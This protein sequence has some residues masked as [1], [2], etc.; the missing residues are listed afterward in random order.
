MHTTAVIAASTTNAADTAVTIDVT[1]DITVADAAAAN[2]VTIADNIT[3]LIL[4]CIVVICSGNISICGG[5]GGYSNGALKLFE[6]R[7]RSRRVVGTRN[8]KQSTFAD[9]ATVNVIATTT[10]DATVATAANIAASTAAAVATDS[11]RQHWKQARARRQYFQ[12][13]A[14][15]RF[16]NQLESVEIRTLLLFLCVQVR[17]KL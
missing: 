2:A 8:Y 1:A 9:A 17:M 4:V 13:N 11:I 14:A 5:G 12:Q 3:L 7:G 6:N 10:A 16:H 15:S